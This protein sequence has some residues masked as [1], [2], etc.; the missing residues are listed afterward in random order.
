[1]TLADTFELA[2]MTEGKWVW[3]AW[4]PSTGS[5]QTELESKAGIEHGVLFP[6]DFPNQLRFAEPTGGELDQR[7]L[8]MLSGASSET[9]ASLAPQGRQCSPGLSGRSRVSTH[10]SGSRESSL[11]ARAA[12]PRWPGRVVM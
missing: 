2:F 9:I 5:S 8:H 4:Q 10:F 7:Y 11:S 6:S 12:S 3:W 1:M